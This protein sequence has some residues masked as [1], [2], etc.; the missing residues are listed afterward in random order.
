MDQPVHRPKSPIFRELKEKG[1]LLK[2]ADGSCSSGD[3]WQPGW[4]FN[5][6][7]PDACRWYADKLKG[8]V[9]IGVDCFKTDL[10][11]RI[12]TDVGGFDGSRSAEDA[13][14]YATSTTNWC[15]TC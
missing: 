4:R 5:F 8:P 14:H 12:P 2:R 6:T 9:E 11:E 1:Y 7:N 10:G 13:S 15:G 3:K